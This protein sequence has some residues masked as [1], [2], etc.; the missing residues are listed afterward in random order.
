M[1]SRVNR[2]SACRRRASCSAC[3]RAAV[4]AAWCSGCQAVQGSKRCAASGCARCPPACTTPSGCTAPPPKARCARCLH[5]LR[6]SPDFHRR[7]PATS[8]TAASSPMRSAATAARSTT[9]GRPCWSS[10]RHSIHDTALRPGWRW[11]RAEAQ[12]QHGCDAAGR[13][14]RLRLV[15]GFGICSGVFGQKI[16]LRPSFHSLHGPSRKTMRPSSSLRPPAPPSRQPP[17]LRGLRRH[18]AASPARGRRADARPRRSASTRPRG[19]VTL[20]PALDLR[21]ACPG[22][23]ARPACRAAST[24]SAS[25]RKA[26]AATTAT[27]RA[28]ASSPTGGTHGKFGAPGSHAGELPSIGGR[29]LRRGP[30]QRG[31]ST[32]SR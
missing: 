7:A 10:S 6:R 19:T 8:V 26:T 29:C 12:G 18:V 15:P 21:R 17:L 4:V 11:A 30:L 22:E 31:R 13:P 32:R 16:P 1:W 14:R 28:A 27:P 20:H 9:H 3:S 5:A 2:G 24:V 23:S 25:R